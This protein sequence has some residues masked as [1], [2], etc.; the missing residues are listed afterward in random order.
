MNR[1]YY[2]IK[3]W[4]I[5]FFITTATILISCANTYAQKYNFT[6]Y[7]IEDGLIQSQVNMLSSDSAHR[8]WIGTL[9]GACRFDGKDYFTLSK[10]TGLNNNFVYTIFNDKQGTVWVGTHKGFSR[11]KNNKIYNYP[12]PAHLKNTWVTQIVQD[13]KGTI[14][15]LMVNRL[16]KVSGQSISPV[17][18]PGA[19]EPSVTA[20]AVD[21]R[22]VLHAV[23]YK[24]GL[25]SL[26]NN[27]WT[28]LLSFT[29]EYERLFVSRLHFDRKDQHT[30]YLLSP[31]GVFV[32][33]NGLISPF[34]KGRQPVIEAQCMSFEQD[35]DNNIW[36]GTGMGAYY[37]KN[38]SY[39]HFTAK[40]GFTDNPVTDI[41]KDADNNL[42]M[43]TSGS[44][45]FKYEG[46]AYVTY[47]DT[48][49]K[50]NQVIMGIARYKNND[51]VLGTDAGL[52]KFNE[53]GFTQLSAKQNVGMVQSLFNDSKGNLWIGSNSAWKYD[54]N[55]F[56]QIKGTER[57]TI[58]AFTEDESG[59]IWIGTP[60]GCF[61][62]EN[63]QL[64]PIEGN[65]TFAS[66]LLSIGKDSVLAGTQEGVVLFV[67]RKIVPNFKIPRLA[68]STIFCMLKNKGV[69]L[70]GTDDKGVFVWDRH[71]NTIRNYTDK[72]GLKSNTVYGMAA[73]DKGV[74]WVGTYKRGVAYYHESIIKFPLYQ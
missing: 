11:F 47:D 50:N 60:L 71:K 55:N 39:T 49:I 65:N 13:G 43:A 70:I 1:F 40:N 67:N 37:F 57:R 8:L 24:K 18:V 9:G 20:I 3:H 27:K 5:L 42:W 51:I 72:H 44:G 59:T 46:D 35:A 61:Y 22:G 58:L 38:G 4:L 68:T 29:G 34:V 41:Y 16:Y 19:D 23:V 30:A 45:V 69:I 14:W 31:K 26:Q 53:Q 28:N 62:Y 17:T 48:E 56:E 10:A 2:S 73:D 63:N 6:H 66:S 36:I 12:V 74:I 32:A 52:L 64:N 7:D 33:K 25:Y 15:L 21:K 54:G